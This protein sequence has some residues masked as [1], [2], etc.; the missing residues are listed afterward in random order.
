M[1]SISSSRGNSTPKPEI[2]LESYLSPV[3]SS[4]KSSLHHKTS[5]LFRSILG[6]ISNNTLPAA[7]LTCD[8]ESV[9]S[10]ILIDTFTSYAS[11]YNFPYC[12]LT[13]T[14]KL[15][16]KN[17]ILRL[18]KESLSQNGG[19]VYIESFEEWAPETLCFIFEYF[20]DFDKK[21]GFVIDIST[22]PRCISLALDTDILQKLSVEQFSFPEFR[23]ISGDIL[24]DLTRRCNFPVMTQELFKALSESRSESMFLKIL[25]SSLLQFFSTNPHRVQ[26]FIEESFLE[27]FIIIKDTWTEYLEKLQKMADCEPVA[28]GTQIQNLH[29]V[30]YLCREIDECTFVK[31]MMGKFKTKEF[32]EVETWKLYLQNLCVEVV[33]TEEEVQKLW[34]VYEGLEG[35]NPKMMK[36]K[37]VHVLPLLRGKVIRQLKPLQE[38]ISRIKN[39]NEYLLE[40]C[41]YLDT[42]ILSKTIA[43]LGEFQGGEMDDLFRIFHCIKRNGR[44]IELNS[45]F[46]EYVKLVGEQ[47]EK[48]VLQ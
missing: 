43:Q 38:C 2:P 8:M 46:N 20:C 1:H 41:R 45:V 32:D 19:I 28:M 13:L 27:E 17:Q 6:F 3:C 5:L 9:S 4:I 36:W 21:V 11:Q 44:F 42:D 7:I 34:D 37:N 26:I 48:R 30:V 10:E 29:R 40:Q 15:S 12:I 35:G 24:W 22:D 23:E 16:T 25:K 14:S 39:A 31:D 33:L 47:E 18:L